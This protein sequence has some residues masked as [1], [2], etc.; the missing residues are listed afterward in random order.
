[1]TIWAD[2]DSLPSQIRAI[3][4]RRN[5]KSVPNSKPQSFI[6]VRFVSCKKLPESRKGDPSAFILVEQTPNA[7]DTYILE[8]AV[9]ADIV[10]TRDIIFAEK[11]LQ[12]KLFVLNDRGTI[13]T[14]ETIKERIS[15][16]NYAAMLREAGVASSSISAGI[17]K[18]EIKN[19]ADTLDKTIIAS[20]KSICS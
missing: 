18:Q 1:M 8:H 15:Q 7:A 4:L 6:Q 16:R 9:S 13:W 5:G 2:A 11:A 10:V 14:E 20:Y 17:S 12:Q 3:I 19:F